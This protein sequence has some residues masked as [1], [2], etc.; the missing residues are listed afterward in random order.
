M[1]STKDFQTA[2]TF[3]IRGNTRISVGRFRRQSHCCNG[4]HRTFGRRCEASF[5]VPEQMANNR[6]VLPGDIT[7][8]ADLR[9]C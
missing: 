9:P 8:V 6:I 4:R 3:R 1:S 2:R 5:L 7:R